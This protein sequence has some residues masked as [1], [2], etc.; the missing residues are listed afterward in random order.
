M[1]N[2]TLT[3]LLFALFSLPAFV[4]ARF[5]SRGSLPMSGDLGRLGEA[6]QARINQRLAFLMRCV[7]A[8]ILAC[9]GGIWLAAGDQSLTT[10]FVIGMAVVV[11]LFI[12]AMLLAIWRIKRDARNGR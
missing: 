11:N 12:L 6:D 4:I 8:S 1:A 10:A 5:L 7:G 2:H 3:A 9:A